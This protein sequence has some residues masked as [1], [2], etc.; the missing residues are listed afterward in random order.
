MTGEEKM[1]KPGKWLRNFLVGKKDK[2]KDK[3]KSKQSSASAEN[4]TTPVPFA[5]STPKEKRRWSFRRSSATS[6]AHKDSSSTLEMTP[7][8]SSVSALHGAMETESE[9]RRHALAVAAATADAAA[10]AAQAAAA[11]IQLATGAGPRVNPV[12]E[13]A[14]TRIQSVYRS[15]LVIPH[16]MV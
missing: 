9:Q 12:E 13:A 2:V 7:G 14:A 15:Y 16:L 10:A 6:V 11:I 1:G 3:E 4:P 8:S 5:P